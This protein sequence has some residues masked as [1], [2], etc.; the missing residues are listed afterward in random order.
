MQN[1]LYEKLVLGTICEV[2]ELWLF[3][4]RDMST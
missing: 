1:K 2:G 4:K 3:H